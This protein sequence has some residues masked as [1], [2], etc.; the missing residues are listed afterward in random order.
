VT[1]FGTV[2]V[3]SA[4]KST[5]SAPTGATGSTP[6]HVPA[7]R[8]KWF[9]LIVVCL[10]QLMNILDSTIV[11]VALPKIQHDLSFSQADLAWV[12]DAYLISLGSFLLLAGRLGDLV[13]RK[14]IFLIGVASFTVFSA[15]CGIADSQ[16][17]LIAARFLQGIAA[18]LC[19]SV[20]LAIISTEFT[21]PSERTKAM[22][23]YVFVVVS[24]GSLGLLLGGVLTQFINWRW[25]FFINVPIGIFAL[26]AGYRVLDENKGLGLSRDIDVLGSLL[27]TGGAMIGVYGIVKAPTYGW[28][29]THTLGFI[30]AAL[31]ILAAFVALESRLKNPIMPLRVFRIRSL[32]ASS[33]VRGMLITGMFT[34]F[35]L[36]ALY[37]Q[38]VLG[39]TPL[40]TGLA[41]LPM[42]IVV[43]VMSRGVTTK[44]VARFG[45]LTMV[46]AGLVLVGISLSLMSRVTPTT[47]YAPLLI[48]SYL[49]LGLGAGSAMSPLLTIALSEVPRQDAGLGSGIVNVS[50]QLSSALG[51][52]ILGAIAT[53]RSASLMASGRS[54]HAALTAGYSLGFK[55]G[56]GAVFAGALVAL[57]LLSPRRKRETAEANVP[58]AE[59]A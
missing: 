10:A 11:N 14:K 56:A 32:I 48:G 37:L 27:V 41:F 46:V 23:A 21:E 42:T 13:G 24:G 55:V 25:D 16:F 1:I 7:D 36:G 45:N 43:G 17:V 31:V 15:I 30:A 8:R 39:Y 3:M 33:V 34:S 47:S 53:D 12:L 35:F 29:S 20:V 57:V 52:A 54:A 58:Q 38:R 5:S 51:V 4:T 18:A 28:G 40:A 2:T 59:S 44:L 26:I 22:S 49:L 19:S 9:A 6:A 50:L